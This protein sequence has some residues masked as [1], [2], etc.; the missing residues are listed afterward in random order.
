[1]SKDYLD[2]TGLT[3][4]WEK[5]K[6]LVKVT[7]KKTVHYVVGTNSVAA[8]TTSP[9]TSSIWKGTDNSVTELY[10]GLTIAFKVDVAGNGTYGTL[11][12]LNNLGN[13][14]VVYNINSMISTRYG[15]GSVIIATYDSASSGVGYLNSSGSTTIQGAW[16][17]C[18]YDSTNVYQLRHNSG[19]YLGDLNLYRYKLL[20]SKNETTL[21]V[22]NSNNNVTA[23]TKTISTETFNPFGEILYYNSTTTVNTGTAIAATTLFSHVTLDLRH[24]FNITSSQFTSNK[25][26]Y[27]VCELVGKNR[28]KFATKIGTTDVTGKP[29]VQALP[30]SDDGL[31]YIYLGHTY[32]AY[33]LELEQDHPVYWYKD[34]SVKLYTGED[35]IPKSKIDTSISEGSTSTNL[36]TS[37]AVA[38][39]VSEHS[40]G[41]GTDSTLYLPIEVLSLDKAA[42]EAQITTAFGGIDNIKAFRK[43]IEDGQPKIAFIETIVDDRTTVAQVVSSTYRKIKNPPLYIE[44][45]DKSGE[46]YLSLRPGYVEAYTIGV[47]R[48]INSSATNFIH[49]NDILNICFTQS[50]A[51]KPDTQFA[52]SR[53]CPSLV[54][55]DAR[56]YDMIQD[57]KDDKAG[58]YASIPI[59]GGIDYFG[60][61]PP[62]GF[63]FADGSAISR[64]EY[65]E[66][67][68][69][70]GTTYGVGD[71]STTF[72]LPDKR[73]RVSVGLLQ[74]DNTFNTLGKTG[75]EKTHII[76]TAEMPSHRHT[77]L[78]VNNPK[79]TA[80]NYLGLEKANAGS[81]IG[82]TNNSSAGVYQYASYGGF[83]GQFGASNSKTGNTGDSG[84]HNNLQPYLVCNY[85]IRAK[86]IAV[87]SDMT[88]QDINTIK[89]DTKLYVANNLNIY[90]T[91]EV[92][93]GTWIDGKTIYRR[94][95]KIRDSV[96]AATSYSYALTYIG[97]SQMIHARL[98]YKVFSNA[99]GYIDG[100]FYNPTSSSTKPN[101]FYISA[102]NLSYRTEYE[103]TDLYG[104]FEYT[105]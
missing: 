63:L 13:H 30:T 61:T 77:G 95:V 45:Y 65:S 68:A 22:P 2:K 37:K 32:S 78:Q 54:Q 23:T 49:T 94:V 53:V 41:G 31:I 14:P 99:T 93:I 70:L 39:Y 29:L 60:M 46:D 10:D 62:P 57:I 74:T 28:C 92:A 50:S 9:Y 36:P 72:N 51:S 47:K 11:L 16:K 102:Y 89:E 98:F 12:N 26:L 73:T 66:L 82:N 44:I 15:V 90:S 105:K 71:G 69:V 84:A 58:A 86:N 79:A 52:F 40:G 3:R 43:A 81:W 27:L 38:E 25:D 35:Y 76:T 48:L 56:L 4:L 59:G 67:F 17:V 97:Y 5:I 24:S 64:T 19:T 87:T 101:F 7:D 75:G 104:I 100:V 8:V 42:T 91:N 96:A 33:Q 80:F 88:I 21:M 103:G 1:M 85:I 6:S 18:D 83:T 20:F 55:N 34:G